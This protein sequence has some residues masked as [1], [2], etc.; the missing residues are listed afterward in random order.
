MIGKVVSH[1]KILEELGRGGM[2][3]VYKA[4]DTKLDRTVAL[5]FLR[6]QDLGGEEEKARFIHEAKAAAA[7]NHPN[8]CTIY[9]IDEHE[10]NSF[11]AMEFVEGRSLKDKIEEGPL[12]LDDAVHIA[13]QAA[14][15]LAAAHEK[16]IV[17]R[18]IKSAN[19]MITEKDRVK[20]MDFGLAKSRGATQLT[21][22][23]TTL[24]TIAYMSPEQA[25]GCVADHRSDIWSLG[26]VLYE[27]IAGTQPFRGE[28]EQAVVY[29]IINTE[30]EPLTALRTGVPMALERIVT[31]CLAKDL[32]ERYQTAKDLAADLRRIQRLESA[33]DWRKRVEEAKARRRSPRGFQ[34]PMGRWLWL[35][36]ICVPAIAVLIITVIVPRYF[37]PVVEQSGPQRKMLAVLPFENLGPA[38]DEYFADG[39]TEEIMTRL[40]NLQGLGVIARTSIMQYKDTKKSI[41][42]I[43]EELGVDYILEGTVRWQRGAQGSFRVRVNPQLIHV[44][45]ATHI[46]A[47]SYDEPMSE[48]FKVQSDIAKMVAQELKVTLLEP[49]G[50]STDLEPTDDF[51]AYTYYLRGNDI[52]HY[53]EAEAGLND[54][55]QMYEKAVA[56]DPEFAHAYVQLSMTHGRIY[57]FHYDRTEERIEKARTSAERALELR[58]DLPEAHVAMGYYHYHCHLDYGR[59]LEEFAIAAR[60]HPNTFEVLHG[61]GLV[62]RRQ[63][64]WAEAAET[65]KKA[66]ELNPTSNQTAYETGQAYYA[67]RDYA[68]AERYFERTQA[69]APELFVP[70]NLKALCYLNWRGDV[71]KAREA[72]LEAAKNVP[73]EQRNLIFLADWK[74]FLNKLER[75]Y[76]SALGNL[77][78]LLSDAEDSQWRFAPKALNYAELY[79][80]LG[81]PERARS[82]YDTARIILEEKVQEHPEDPRFHASLGIAH[83]GLGSKEQAIA[84]GKRAVELLP[85]SKEAWR[86]YILL[87][88]LATIYVMTGEYES[89]LDTIEYLL[90]IP[91]GVSVPMLRLDPLWDPLRDHPRFEHILKKYTGDAS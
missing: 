49:K 87:E 13:I 10:G 3:I 89:A 43:G 85:M 5:K 88:N 47:H 90:S 15:G 55:L 23:G 7:L 91:G 74:W 16:E 33:Q 11:I 44:E 9:E 57:W 41:R 58:P 20:I 86:G 39:I 46:W 22:E 61:I 34:T 56:L 24:G 72:I 80:L 82:Y 31:R 53:T 70:Y 12:K 8:I 35:L 48:V 21:R 28:Y 59:A 4:E 64:R 38:E 62:Q 40:A 51:E 27:M 17:H 25:R 45:D 73:M 1:Y 63:G 68:E 42:E 75:N 37:S 84:E 78:S 36:L 81:Q 65:L 30:P 18:D 77:D 14:E 79:D 29:S 50:G 19:I 71:E 32:A 2:G 67:L 52:M 83:A 66:L 54:A 76:E 6:P 26:A 69:L 60:S